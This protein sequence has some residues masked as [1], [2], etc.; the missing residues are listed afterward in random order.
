MLL[1]AHCKFHFFFPL[2]PDVK[3]EFSCAETVT[4]I[5]RTPPGLF[6]LTSCSFSTPSGVLSVRPKYANGTQASVPDVTPSLLLASTANTSGF[7]INNRPLNVG[8]LNYDAALIYSGER[9][10]SDV[11]WFDITL[12]AFDNERLCVL[13]GKPLKSEFQGPCYSTLEF[14]VYTAA[15]KICNTEMVHVVE[16]SDPLTP[17][18]SIEDFYPLVALDSDLTPN[19]VT[20]TMDIDEITQVGNYPIT[21]KA[22]NSNVDTPVTC[23]STVSS[24]YN[25]IQVIYVI[26]STI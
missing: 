10:S 14:R 13:G 21:F 5:S 26:F 25:W 17:P 15:F 3:P 16:A 1:Y 9:I 8:A 2:A 11:R 19:Q 23:N 7:F 18:L 4:Q 20:A 24:R 6:A 12:V 22:N